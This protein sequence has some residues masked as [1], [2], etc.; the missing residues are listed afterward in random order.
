MRVAVTGGCGFLG[1]AFTRHASDAG[2]EVVT[3]DRDA[4]ADVVLDVA[5]SPAVE[6]ALSRVRPHAVMHLAAR[7]T[8]AAARDPVGAVRVNGLGTACVFAAAEAAG[9]ARVIYASSNAAVGR[10]AA[11]AG[12]DAALDPQTIYGATKAFGE[13]LARVMSRHERAPAYLAL[14]FGWIYGPGRE[15]G[16]AEPQRVIAEAIH[17]ARA[18]RYPDYAQAIDWTY[19]DD[20]AQVLVRALACP[21]EGFAVHN[22]LGDRRR[23]GDAIAHLRVRFADL[24]A[25]PYAATLPDSAWDLAG[26]G[27]AARIGA[28]P[29]TRLED[30]IDRMIVEAR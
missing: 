9:V 1:A 22:A 8:D 3:L 17:G 5:D 29:L 13:H 24:D 28:V 11:A 20:A 26:D 2:H 15:R 21:L 16:W 27:L 4:T 18:I 30:G 23:M 6:S 10:C 12:D 7:L 14:R 19:V 25:R